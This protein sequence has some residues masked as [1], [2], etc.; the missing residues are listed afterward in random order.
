MDITANIVKVVSKEP[1][2]ELCI[3]Y[4]SLA[5]GNA[6]TSSDVDIA[7]AGKKVFPKS[8]LCDLNIRMSELTGKEVDI[9][10][11]TTK[12]GVI[13]QQALCTGKVLINK[14]PDIYASLIKKMWYNQQDMMPNTRKIWKRHQELFFAT[15]QS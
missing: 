5:K 10:D 14:S 11:L 8:F 7:I 2:V 15:N 3:L 13:L 4:G 9:I 1:D 12:S 6:T